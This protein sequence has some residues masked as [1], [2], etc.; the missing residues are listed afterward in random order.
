MPSDLGDV[1]LPKTKSALSVLRGQPSFIVFISVL[2]NWA[3]FSFLRGNESYGP[4]QKAAKTSP[5]GTQ[6]S[7][8]SS[9]PDP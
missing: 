8:L 2:G 4:F 5:L 9:I 6:S 3:G 7:Q 1:C